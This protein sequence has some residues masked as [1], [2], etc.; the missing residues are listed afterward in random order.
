MLPL[1][2]LMRCMHVCAGSKLSMDLE[3]GRLMRKSVSGNSMWYDSMQKAIHQTVIISEILDSR[4]RHLIS[5]RMPPCLL[6]AQFSSYG[7]S[8]LF[9]VGTHCWQ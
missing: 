6:S 4:T 1:S 5:V 8:R 3:A 2:S 9:C 7:A